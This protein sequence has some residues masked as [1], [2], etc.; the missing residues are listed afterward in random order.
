MPFSHIFNGNLLNFNQMDAL[1][2]GGDN[3]AKNVIFKKGS[4]SNKSTNT[5]LKSN[6]VFE[7]YNIVQQRMSEK[8]TILIPSF[9]I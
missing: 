6:I 5:Y 2:S 8:W 4:E 3:S 9:G 7:Q 1:R